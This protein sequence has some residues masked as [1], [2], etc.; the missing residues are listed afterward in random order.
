LTFVYWIVLCLFVLFVC[1]VFFLT[2]FMSDC[3]MTELV[4]LRSDMCVCV[5]VYVCTCTTREIWFGHWL[6]DFFLSEPSS[7]HLTLQ[8]SWRWNP[9]SLHLLCYKFYFQMRP[10][11]TDFF[12]QFYI[13]NT[14]KAFSCKLH[15]SV[16][17]RRKHTLWFTGYSKINLFRWV[18]PTHTRTVEIQG[19]YRHLKYF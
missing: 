18:L 12:Y 1:Y 6:P 13:T 10:V 7:S 2:V 8:L 19:K 3:C 16:E 9:K 14:A 17:N 11:S 15:R 4:D 5:C